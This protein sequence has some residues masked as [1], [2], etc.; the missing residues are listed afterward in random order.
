MGVEYQYVNFTKK[1]RFGISPFGG[2]EK[3][4]GIGN[5]IG[6]R[7]LGLM[8]CAPDNIR[9]HGDKSK[10]F[11]RWHCDS[12]AVIGDGNNE[13]DNV[14]CPNYTDITANVTL[15]IYNVD[16]FEPLLEYIDVCE[17]FFL[18]L[19]YLA[20]SNQVQH[21]AD[22]MAKHFGPDYLKKYGDIMKQRPGYFR[23]RDLVNIQ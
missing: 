4:S 20:L 1:E 5:T 3:F 19:S 14:I 22:E 16:G 12:I 2:N 7:A 11:G 21:L 9:G 17:T 8:L 18:Q 6:A 23:P 13:W 10:L 15:L